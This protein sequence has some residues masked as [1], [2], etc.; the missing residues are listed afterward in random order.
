MGPDVQDDCAGAGMCVCCFLAPE[1]PGGR[2]TVLGAWESQMWRPLACLSELSRPPGN[3][4]TQAPFPA[5]L[6][7]PPPQNCGFRL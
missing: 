4:P 1:E 2:G 3:S 7:P 5:P 6:S